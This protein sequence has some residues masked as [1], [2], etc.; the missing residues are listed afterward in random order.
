[1]LRNT[2]S[3][4]FRGFLVIAHVPGQNTMLLGQFLP[5]NSNQQTIDCDTVGA[6][7]QA[8]ITHRNAAS[9]DFSQMNFMWQ[10]PSG[11]NGTVN[12]R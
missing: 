6:A 7:T 1:M 8:T 9:T 5:Q 4:T 11:A 3:Q 12:F 10:A 2:Q